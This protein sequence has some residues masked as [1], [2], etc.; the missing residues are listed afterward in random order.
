MVTSNKIQ[1]DEAVDM[2]NVSKTFSQ[3]PHGRGG[4]GH[5]GQPPKRKTLIEVEEHQHKDKVLLVVVVQVAFSALVATT[6][7]TS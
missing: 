2:V 1:A 4:G 7:P 5:V 6:S 3:P